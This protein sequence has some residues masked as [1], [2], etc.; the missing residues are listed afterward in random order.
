M[1]YI[2]VR[3]SMSKRKVIKHAAK[4]CGG[5]FQVD[6]NED[7]IPILV[8][9]TCEHRIEDWVKWDTTYRNF[10]EDEDRW[11]SK[12]D[13]LMCLLGY[14]V[15]LYEQY[16]GTSFTFSLNEKGLFR[17]PELYHIR[18]M[19][20]ML[21]SDALLGKRYMD[22]LFETKVRQRKKRITSLGFLATP[23]V[24]TEFKLYLQRSMRIKRDTPL[25][26]KMLEWVEQ[27]TPGLKEVVALA[28]HGDLHLLLSHY[29]RGHFA[30]I[31]AVDAFIAKLKSNSYVDG[32]L[33]IKNWSE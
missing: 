9:D 16:Y 11:V 32:D 22:W 25:P 24:I 27:Y 23:G 30:E 28:D 10:W 21:N 6:Y 3:G 2:S 20:A 4:K 12:K 13:H 8:C 19:Y 1:L 15:H 5:E 7:N 14:F 17:G 18:R 33:N 29:K 26:P 31:P